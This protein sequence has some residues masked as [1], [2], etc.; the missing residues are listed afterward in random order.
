MSRW[1]TL[2]VETEG[3]GISTP[4]SEQ[5]NL[6]GGLLGEVIREQAGDFMLDLVEDLRLLCKKAAQPGNEALLDQVEQ[7]VEQLDLQQITWLLRAYTAFF[8]LVNQAEQQEITRINRERARAGSDEAPRAESIEEAIHDLKQRGFSLEDVLDVIGRLDI[9]PTL[10]AHPT[11]ARRRSILFK[12]QR[13]AATLAQMR[14]C[15]YTPEE[16]DHALAE[17]HSQIALLLATDEVRAERMTVEDEV[18]HGL[19]FL[20]NTIWDT[21]PRIYLDIHRALRHYYGATPHLPSFLRFRSWIGSDRDGNPFVT[22]EVTRRTFRHQRATALERLRIELLELRREMSIS[23][24]QATIPPELYESIQKDAEEVDLGEAKRR[25][26]Q[27]EPYRLKTSYMIA[28]LEQLQAELDATGPLVSQSSYRCEHFVDDLHVMQRCLES[29][30]FTEMAREGKL[31]TVLVHAEAF[32]FHMA[33]LDVRQHSNVHEQTVA[34]LLQIAGVEAD[35]ASCPEEERLRILNAEL[36]NPRPLLPR[37]AD[38]PEAARQLMDTLEVIG[39][40]IT[41]DPDAA[42]IYIISMTHTVSDMLEVMLVAKEAGLWRMQDGQVSSPLDVVPLFETIEDLDEAEERMRVLFG[43]DIY[44]KHLAAR[45]NFQ[46]IMLGYSDSN[47]DGG[48]WMANWALHRAQASLGRVCRAHN[49]DFRLFHG[50]GGTV[51]RGGGRANQAIL[52]MAPVVH[53]GRIRFTEQGEVISFRYAIPDI[54]RRHL[55]QIVN[56][57]IRSTAQPARSN[58]AETETHDRDDAPLMDAISE[59]SMRAYRDLIDDPNLW[60]WYTRVTPI[61]QISRLPIASRPV[62]RKSAQEVDF[63][64]LR[65]IP[66]NFAW[67]QTRYMVPGWYGI[68]QAIHAATKDDPAAIDRLAE[69]YRSWHFFR[70]IVNNAQREMARARFEIARHY[71]RLVGSKGLALHERIAADF[72]QA[73]DAVLRITGQNA[74]L[75]NNPIIQKSISLRNPY[76]D[77]LNLLQIELIKRYRNA[78]EDDKEPLRQAI[79]LSI[80]GIAAAVQSTG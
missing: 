14:Q 64:S 9:Q 78:A 57:M 34:A 18:E 16:V 19:Y 66:W 20:R 77:V 11:E 75:D 24:R 17:V 65:A 3:T 73:R 21:L 28:R 54:G 5:V 60:P 13:I 12:Q 55:E 76:T 1:K 44:R 41:V 23:E 80:N 58:G 26:Y 43:N 50:R 36:A 35:Y 2:H 6:L 67:T 79:F 33:A 62:S 40:I 10:T 22:P 30:G 59:H 25:Q 71:A 38:L 74:L 7:K 61:E 52:A 27:Y 4:L 47:K 51:G 48:Y 32:G 53:N 72:E 45:G 39:E 69:L 46:E 56:A 63:D 49:V 29:T 37:G 8:H 31:H 42:G 15:S 68:G 70:A